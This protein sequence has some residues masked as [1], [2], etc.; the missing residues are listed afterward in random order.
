METNMKSILCV[1]IALH[2]AVFSTALVIDSQR[3]MLHVPATEPVV[4]EMHLGTA[5]H[6]LQAAKNATPEVQKSMQTTATQ[7]LEIAP[8][9][10]ELPTAAISSKL[11]SV[12][13]AVAG[14]SG[15]GTPVPSASTSTTGRSIA[16]G[17]AHEGR[18]TAQTVVAARADQLPWIITSPAP[19]Y[20][21]EARRKGWI[22]RVS[23]H[24]LITEKGTVQ[25]TEIIA[26]SGHTEL[27]EAALMA[28]RKWTF[29]P[30]QKDG[31]VIAA[32][33]VVPVL[34]RLDS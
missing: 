25:Q 8:P 27:D 9:K 12:D 11:P 24:V 33:V 13:A 3:E 20:P 34:F 15:D 23:V 21:R 26:S 29:H 14:N 18:D 30:A 19:E 28:L 4:L 2:M 6:V 17:T 31:H 22:G 10:P 16:A 5:P 32:W 7:P 1:S